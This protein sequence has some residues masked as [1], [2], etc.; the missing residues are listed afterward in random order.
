MERNGNATTRAAFTLK[1]QRTATETVGLCTI[2]VRKR[3]QAS[4]RFYALD[5]TR[6]VLIEADSEE[7]ARYLCRDVRLEFIDLCEK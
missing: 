1:M 3:R 2:R 5:G 6:C 4:V 7:G